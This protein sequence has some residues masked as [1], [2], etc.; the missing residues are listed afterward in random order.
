MDLVAWLMCPHPKFIIKMTR[1]YNTF[2]QHKI[3]YSIVCKRWSKHQQHFLFFWMTVTLSSGLSSPL[4]SVLVMGTKRWTGRRSIS[5]KRWSSESAADSIST[6][7]GSV[8]GSAPRTVTLLVR[9]CDGSGLDLSRYV[10][11]IEKQSK[12]TCTYNLIGPV[13]SWLLVLD[14]CVSLAAD[15][16][17]SGPL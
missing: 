14:G 10:F 9:D 17:C 12:K 3:T 6:P 4:K 16:N 11:R 5:L 7:V 1:P 8:F 15:G 13:F 2:V